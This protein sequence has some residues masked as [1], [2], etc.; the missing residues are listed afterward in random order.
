[1]GE[2]DRRMRCRSPFNGYDLCLPGG[3]DTGV[4]VNESVCRCR[5]GGYCRIP[6]ARLMMG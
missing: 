6:I 2:A 3:G 5:N 1:M 4:E